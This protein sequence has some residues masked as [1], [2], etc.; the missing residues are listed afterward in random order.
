MKMRTTGCDKVRMVVV[1]GSCPPRGGDM[2]EIGN[3]IGA[4]ITEPFSLTVSC[5]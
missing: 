5:L 2:A 4:A 3:G 1:K